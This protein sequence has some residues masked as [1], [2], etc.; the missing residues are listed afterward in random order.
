MLLKLS[1]FPSSLDL[2]NILKYERSKKRDIFKGVKIP[3]KGW[4]VITPKNIAIT[5][6][7]F[8]MV[9]I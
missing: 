7:Y 2:F 8:W 1:Y 9:P 5:Q 6:I 4:N 3:V